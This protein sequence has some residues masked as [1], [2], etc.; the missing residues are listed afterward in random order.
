MLKIEKNDRFWEQKL[1]STVEHYYM[2]QDGRDYVSE[3]V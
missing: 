1:V 3:R 2:V